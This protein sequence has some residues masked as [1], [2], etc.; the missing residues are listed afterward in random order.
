MGLRRYAGAV[1][2]TG[3]GTRPCPP[4]LAEGQAGGSLP[5]V[6]TQGNNPKGKLAGWR[7]NEAT[8][9]YLISYGNRRESAGEKRRQSPEKLIRW[10]NQC[11]YNIKLLSTTLRERLSHQEG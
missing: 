4:K 2:E 7:R 6:I 8:L 9:R 3:E 11:Y 10:V 5:E 1:P